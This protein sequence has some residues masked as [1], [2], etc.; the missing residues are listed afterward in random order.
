[1]R[2]NVRDFQNPIGAPV[3]IRQPLIATVHGVAFVLA[4]DAPTLRSVIRRWA[5]AAGKYGT[6][7]W[8]P[9][10]AGDALLLPELAL[11][12]RKFGPEEALSS[13]SLVSHNELGLWVEAVRAAEVVEPEEPPLPWWGKN[14]YG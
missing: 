3:R 9:R 6:L 1:M 8:V 11:L 14:G 2:A 5:W 7:K 4:L 12:A 10:L 13:L